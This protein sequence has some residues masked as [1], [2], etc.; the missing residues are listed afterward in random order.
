MYEEILGI[1]DQKELIHQADIYWPSNGKQI[2]VTYLTKQYVLKYKKT[3]T[4]HDNTSLTIKQNI[5]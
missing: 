5:M 2:Q 1:P 3:S 4:L